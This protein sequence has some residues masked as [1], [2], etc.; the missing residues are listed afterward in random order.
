M[1]FGRRKRIQM[2][3]KHYDTPQLFH[4][5]ESDFWAKVDEVYSKEYMDAE[6]KYQNSLKRKQWR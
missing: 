1:N 5:T 4:V 2:E 3:R 6:V